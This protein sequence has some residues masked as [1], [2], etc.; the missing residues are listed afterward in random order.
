MIFAQ[1]YPAKDIDANHGTWLAR[2]TAKVKG[3]MR[4]WTR[5]S[6]TK[7]TSF[8]LVLSITVLKHEI[9]VRS[10]TTENVK[11]SSK[12]GSV[13]PVCDQ[14]V[15]VDV[16][17]QSDDRDASGSKGDDEGRPNAHEDKDESEDK[18]KDDLE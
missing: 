5:G 9:V 6:S 13:L 14:A 17:R 2:Q 1:S 18:S 16:P 11:I 8:R 15:V 10:I 12:I 7:L 3:G 4:R